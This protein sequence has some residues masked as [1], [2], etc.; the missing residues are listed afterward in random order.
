MFIAIIALLIGGCASATKGMTAEEKEYYYDHRD[1]IDAQNWR[2]CERASE[3]TR[4]INHQHGGRHGDRSKSRGRVR[5]ETKA[6]LRD[7]SCRL[8]LRGEKWEKY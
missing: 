3:Y 2:N 7:N 5:W 1:T 4:H 6:D 8:V